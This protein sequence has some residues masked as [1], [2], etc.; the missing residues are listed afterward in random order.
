ML[1][2]LTIYIPP[3]VVTIFGT[4]LS[5]EREPESRLQS[6]ILLSK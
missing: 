6:F 2:S 5:N 3:Q 1:D 4:I